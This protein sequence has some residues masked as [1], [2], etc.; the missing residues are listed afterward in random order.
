MY[1]KEIDNVNNALRKMNPASGIS[2]RYNSNEIKDFFRC[3]ASAH[4]NSTD[5]K[6]IR[7]HAKSDAILALRLRVAFEMKRQSVFVCLCLFVSC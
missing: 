2:A 5:L 6:R 7:A 1:H 4:F 3:R